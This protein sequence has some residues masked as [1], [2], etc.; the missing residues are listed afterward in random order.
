MTSDLKTV[1]SCSDPSVMV[2]DDAAKKTKELWYLHGHPHSTRYSNPKLSTLGALVKHNGQVFH[3]Q[4][5]FMYPVSNKS[6]TTYIPVAWNQFHQVTNRLAMNYGHLL[7]SEITKGRSNLNQPTVALLGGGT[8]LEYFCTQIALQKLNLR[9]LLLADRS[10]IDVIRTLLV[11]CQVV[12]IIY[13]L[14][15]AELVSKS[16]RGVPMIKMSLLLDDPVPENEIEGL[17]FDDNLD[18]WERHSFILHSSGSTG[19][20]KAI[21]HTN[22]SMML[23]AR[24]YRLF[25]DFHIENWFL[26]FPLYH[27]AGISIMLSGLPNGLMTSLPPLSWPPSAS[28]ILQACE[29]LALSH[30]PVDCIHCAPTIIENLY[31]YITK[32]SKGYSTLASLKVLQPGGAKLS[33]A[34]VS[35]LVSQNVNI[36]TT[37]GSTEIGP[38]MRSIPHSRNNPECYSLR[39]LYPDSDKFEMQDI[40]GGLHEC[41]V[42]KGFELAAELWTEEDNEPYRTN[43]LFK[44]E[45]AGS[46]NFVLQGRRD[47]FLVHSDG[48]NTSAGAL[49]LDIQDVNPSVKNVLAVGHLRPCV[50]LL[51]ELKPDI[52]MNNNEATDQLWLGIQK[53]NRNYPRHSQVLRSMIRILPSGVILP[54]TPKGNVKRNEALASFEDII[55]GMYNDLLGVDETRG[56]RASHD[57]SSLPTLLRDQV[58]KI[59]G[60]PAGDVK[61]TTSFYDIGMDSLSALQLRLSLSKAMG[62]MTLGTIFENPSVGQLTEYFLGEKKTTEASKHIAFIH[63]TIARCTADFASWP[64]LPTAVDDRAGMNTVLLTGASGSLGSALLDVLS[65]SSEVSRIFALVRG[66]NRHASLRKAL[67]N[68]GLDASTILRS[69][70]L[71]LL[72]YSMKDPLLGLDIDTY[73][74]LSKKVTTVIHCAWKVNFNQTV[75][76]FEDDCIRGLATSIG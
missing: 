69:E 37:Y 73:H 34:L 61:D 63:K 46:G 8:T 23:I 45:P 38:P 54:V 50:G 59:F 42:Y 15:N 60:I 66:P 56:E 62:N 13:D 29:T 52:G 67:E 51:V 68:R 55:D 6:D 19:P 1:P 44:E 7:Q 72:N 70:K 5:A 71:E 28:S 17:R 16:V 27:V 21:V 14:R 3:D 24:M 11:K 75:E 35:R 53:V 9:V 76:D 12:V 43:D 22:R 74:R 49:Q 47:D 41:I 32:N 58:S 40:G 33:A 65:T 30:H 26:L 48:N 31:Q 64:N 10:P 2:S 57:Q 18:P 36:K 25:P 20:P 4:V 39:T